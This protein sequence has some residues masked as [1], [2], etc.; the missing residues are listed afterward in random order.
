MGFRR[1]AVRLGMRLALLLLATGAA[2][3]SATGGETPMTTALAFLAA[4]LV[5]WSLW[6]LVNEGNLEMARFVAALERADLGQSFR[7]EGRGAGFD[8]LGAAYTLAVD[9]LRAERAGSVV[10]RRHADAL[11][12][13][14]PVAMLEIGPG[15]A[16]RL[17]NTA[18][19]RLFAPGEPGTLAALAPFGQALVEALRTIAPGRTA[20]S[21][22]VSGGLTQRIALDATTIDLASG[23]RRIVS[24]RVIQA[25]LDA[26]EIAAQVD[27]VRVLTHEVMNSL[28]PVT[29]L[30]GTAERL[31]ADLDPASSPGVAKAQRAVGALARRAAELERFVESYKDFSANPALR[32]VP[33]TIAEWFE[34]LARLF[35]ATPAAEGVLLSWA[36]PPPGVIAIDRGLMTQV[37]LNLLKNAGEAVRGMAAPTITVSALSSADGLRIAVVDNGPG[38]DPAMARDVFLPFF[39]TKAEGTGIGLSFARKVVMLHG[40]RIGFA[41]G[42]GGRVELLLPG[43]TD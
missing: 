19:R 23:R 7:Q 24:V 28:T 12:D 37:M 9:R 21:H 1:F 42:A 16:V 13:G 38:I 33:T 25:E 43:A 41:A 20:S 6:R 18:A 34:E 3:W 32:L 40:G 17:V 10:A 15:D 29:S 5:A 26:A 30:A 11:V 36:P 4:G 31:V 2:A 39:T 8:R 35:A 22:M 14:A 27:L